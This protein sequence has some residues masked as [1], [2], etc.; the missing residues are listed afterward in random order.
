M[1]KNTEKDK[2]ARTAVTVLEILAEHTPVP[3]K[4]KK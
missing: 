1:V 4:K 3:S 2:L